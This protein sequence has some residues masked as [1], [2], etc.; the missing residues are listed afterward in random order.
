TGPRGPQGFTKLLGV[1]LDVTDERVARAR[2]QAAEMRLRDAIE[3][4]SD[5]FVLFDRHDRL[6][7]WN[8]AFGDSFGIDARAL[9][10]GAQ[11]DTLAKIAAL[12]IK[13]ETP[14]HDGR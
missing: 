10:P 5:A 8:H 6:I 3:S 1:A 2:V 11:K 9:R 12:S 13:S 14:A 7:L 4:V